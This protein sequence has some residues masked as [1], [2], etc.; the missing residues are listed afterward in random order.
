[1]QEQINRID[2]ERLPDDVVALIAALGPGEELVITRAGV[3]LATVHAATAISG[4]IVMPDRPAGGDPLPPR[5]DVT[6]VATAMRLPEAARTRLSEQLGEDYIVVDLH[7]APV[8]ADV[9]LVPPIS[10]QLIGNLRAMFPRARVVVTE[11]EDESLG[12]SYPGPIRRMLEAGA[13]TYLTSATVPQLARRLDQA[14][15]ATRPQLD[16]PR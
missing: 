6:V 13:E 14:V 15:T 12:V 3:P 5:A 4:T 7:S 10:P 11:L 9:V 1:M 16:A 8:T 2:A